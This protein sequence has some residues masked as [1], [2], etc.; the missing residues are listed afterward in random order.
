MN[1]P[2]KAG[3]RCEVIGGLGRGKSPNL[4]QHVI[5]VSAQG[6][7]SQL[8]PIWRCRGPEVRQLTDGGTYAVT[9]WADFAQSWLR[10]LPH[11][12]PPLQTTHTEEGTKA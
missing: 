9:G 2:I 11:V 1:Q 6:E 10:K 3:D 8:G 5:V 4:G 12:A 7:H